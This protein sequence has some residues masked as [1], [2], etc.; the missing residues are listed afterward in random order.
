TG[1]NV[2]GGASPEIPAARARK[3]ARRHDQA[4]VRGTRECRY[5]PLDLVGVAHAHRSEINPQRLRYSLDCTELAKA[6]RH[7]GIPKHRHTSYVRRDLFEQFHPFSAHAVFEIRET[8]NVASRARK[9][10]D[11]ACAHRIGNI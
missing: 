6:R 8:G 10:L 11:E 2:G 3:P 9:A 4:D 5:A 7:G 1:G